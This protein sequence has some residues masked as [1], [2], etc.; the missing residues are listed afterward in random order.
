MHVS[1]R[2]ALMPGQPQDARIV[3]THGEAHTLW[4][5][6][7]HWIFSADE[8]TIYYVGSCRLRD[9][10][11]TPDALRNTWFAKLT[12]GTITAI[13]VVQTAPDEITVLN[14]AVK[15]GRALKAPCNLYGG[16][17]SPF[18]RVR[19]VETGI[20]YNSAN[21]CCKSMG[22]AQ[23][24]LSQHLRRMSGFKTVKGHTFEKVS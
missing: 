6:Y 3:V 1:N 13:R 2:P 17:R 21:E 7:E 18:H 10:F 4:C 19:C 16:Q 24:A 23:S 20:V 11:D 22:I 5:V 9:V 14:H 8:W 15:L 12:K